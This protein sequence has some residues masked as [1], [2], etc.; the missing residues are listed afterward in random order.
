MGFLEG[1]GDIIDADGGGTRLTTAGVGDDDVVDVAPGELARRAG[2]KLGGQVV[3]L[4]AY[5]LA[6]VIASE[7]SSGSWAELLCIGDADLN[8]ARAEGRS[9]VD[10]ITGGSGLYGSQG[11]AGAGARKRPVSSARDPHVRHLRAARLLLSGEARGWARGARRYFDPK[12]QLALWGTKS[13]SYMHPLDIL[14]RWTYNRAV[15]ANGR[16]DEG[17]RTV[18]L[19]PARA[20]GEEWVGPI[21]NVDAWELMLFRPATDAQDRQYQ[22]AE[23]I[24]RTGGQWQPA[25]G[26]LDSLTGELAGALAVALAGKGLTS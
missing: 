3:E 19:G 18:E 8:R 6:R 2:L 4:E 11:S 24:I 7:H 26:W 10:H 13:Q 23:A 16:D 1:F 21:A 14:D 9:I 20:G 17:R 12:A 15:K 5:S 25:P 22:L